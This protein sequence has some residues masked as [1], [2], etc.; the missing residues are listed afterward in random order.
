MQ[1]LIGLFSL[2]LCAGALLALPASAQPAPGVN[3]ATFTHWI[4]GGGKFESVTQ[5][6]DVL[7]DG[8]V[9]MLNTPGHTPGHHSL[10]VSLKEMGTSMIQAMFTQH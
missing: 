7:G 10:M 5:D 6:K 8:T 1:R 9:V 3:A 4:S 2:G